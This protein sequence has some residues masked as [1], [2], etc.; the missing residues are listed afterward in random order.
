MCDT[1]DDGVALVVEG[2]GEDLVSVAL[3]DLQ[4]D[5]RADVPQTGRPVR[6]GGEEPP[7]L[8]AEAHLQGAAG[9]T[10]SGL[11]DFKGLEATKTT[12]KH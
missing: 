4:A 2:A 3:Q 6:A 5:S 11:V 7:A 12:K 10:H 1:C 9:Q 8:R